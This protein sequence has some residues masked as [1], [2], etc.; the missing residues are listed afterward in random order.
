MLFSGIP[1]LADMVFRNCSTIRTL[2]PTKKQ[3]SL[4]VYS[5]KCK[6]DTLYV[7]PKQ[8]FFKIFTRPFASVTIFA[9]N[10][11]MIDATQAISENYMSER[12]YVCRTPFFFS[13]L[14]ATWDTN[15]F[16]W[17][18]ALDI[19]W[20][21]TLLGCL[22]CLWRGTGNGR[23]NIKHNKAWQSFHFYPFSLLMRRNWIR[24]A[25]S[26]GAEYSDILEGGR[27]WDC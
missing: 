26:L 17:N 19:E 6:N 18:E 15:I 7:G 27:G 25:L 24:L 9:P 16:F 10:H 12:T 22:G 21:Q 4:F 11:Y 20:V 8:S 2:S 3:P 5:K 13:S 23:L 14:C 1:H